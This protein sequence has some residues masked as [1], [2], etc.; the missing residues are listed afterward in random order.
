MRL[1]FDREKC[2]GCMACRMACLDQRDIRP[3]LGEKPL[4]YLVRQE[5]ERDAWQEMRTCIQCGACADVC[6]AEALH[7]DP[8]GVV[9]ADPERCIGCRACGDACPF[10]VISY[11]GDTGIMRKCDL[12]LGRIQAGLLP[13]C[14]HT[15]PT[16]ALTLE[17]D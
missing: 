4:L 16:G 11:D 14:V 5:T 15:C 9:L 2:T 12:C 6:P 10:D 17:L 8:R 1:V 3:A 13:A 7:R